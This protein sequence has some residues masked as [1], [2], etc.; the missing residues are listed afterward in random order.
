MPSGQ[1]AW[2]RAV[3]DAVPQPL[4]VIDTDGAVAYANDAARSALEHS[5]PRRLFGHS[6]HEI[7]HA[8]HVDGS[9]YPADECPI[10]RS[11]ASRRPAS[12]REVFL[13]RSGRAV[14]VSWQVSTLPRASHRLLAFTPEKA[15][16]PRVSPPP[17][18]LGAAPLTADTIRAQVAAGFRDPDLTPDRLARDNHVSLRTLQTVLAQQGQAPATMIRLERLV[19]ARELL[20]QGESP[21]AAA[22]ASGFSDADTFTRAFRRQFGVA[23]SGYAVH[24]G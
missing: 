5:D 3:L 13:G 16:S 22:F 15:H 19:H 21:R 4:L 10:V 11:S 2:T 12:G 17:R 23:P 8:H 7:L 18:T 6:T 1:D 20:R 14:S 9:P 24:T